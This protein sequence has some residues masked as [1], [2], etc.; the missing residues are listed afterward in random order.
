MSSA[1]KKQ[2]SIRGLNTNHNPELKNLFKST[3]LSASI[4]PGPW[5]DCYQQMLAKGIKPRW[6]D[7]PWRARWP[8][9]SQPCGRKERVSITTN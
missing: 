2:I 7:L 9:L 6:R 3:A 1:T 8:R 4:Q 5:Q